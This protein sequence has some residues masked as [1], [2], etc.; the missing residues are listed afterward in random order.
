MKRVDVVYS[1]A[2][3]NG[4]VLMV[5]NRTNQSWTLPGGK[6]EAG[7]SLP[8]AAAREMKEET[9]CGIELLGILALNEAVIDDEHVYFIVFK[10]QLTDRPETITFDENIME[11]KWMPLD[12]A[13]RLLL[14]FHPHGIMHWVNSEGAEYYHEGEK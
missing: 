10:A 9:A 12:E 2:E 4:Q 3:E 11:A 7:E 5:K 1:F 8:E 13:N 6:V 14:V